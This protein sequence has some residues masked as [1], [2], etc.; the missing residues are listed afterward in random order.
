MGAIIDIF[1]VSITLKDMNAAAIKTAWAH[2]SGHDDYIDGA[3][4][5]AGAMAHII[6][7]GGYM[8]MSAGQLGNWGKGTFNTIS[9][10]KDFLAAHSEVS[11]RRHA[12]VRLS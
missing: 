8:L 1:G 3:F 7:N 9:C 10:R 6:A 12:Y 5:W 4:I 11:G 2:P